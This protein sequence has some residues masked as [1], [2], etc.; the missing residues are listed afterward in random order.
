MKK[1]L[2][3]LGILSLL[4]QTQLMSQTT[5][6]ANKCLECHAKVVEKKVIHKPVAE[7][8]DK[9]H[10]SNGK[11]HPKNEVDGFELILPVPQLCYTCH[12]EKSILK[13]QVHS[14]IKEGDCL[15]CHDIHSSKGEHLLSTAP[16]GLCFS[17][18]TDLKKKIEASPVQ[19]AAVKE[20]KACINCHS[21]HSSSQKKIL[22]KAQPDLCYSCHDKVIQVGT[23]TIPN[24]KALVTKS[25]YV[26]GAI[27][28]NGCTICHNPHAS[29]NN[30]LLIK[31][32]PSG[33]Y[34]AA[35]K[36]NYAL[37]L[38]CHESSL[39]QEPVTTELTGFRNGDKNLHFV[40][41][42]K[43]KGRTCL[44]CHNV[45]A[46][47]KLFLIADDV[48]FGQWRMPIRFNKL[49]KGGSCAPGCHSEKKYER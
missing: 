19:H 36:D 8:C 12:E 23:R 32:F 15:S 35:D 33:N 26:H 6:P 44:D 46:S 37:C 24:M 5:V 7:G 2:V 45:H 22:V 11:E 48:K 27:D 20:M 16:P 18:H 1:A 30:Y 25:K 29:E 49:P 47:N 17:C 13:E 10:K 38:D 28:N 39:F 34:S 21:P 4:F 40:H 14:P 3:I 31:P 43:E 9:C 42:N 41:V